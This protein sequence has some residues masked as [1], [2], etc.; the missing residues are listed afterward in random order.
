MSNSNSTAINQLIANYS[1]ETTPGAATKIPDY[2]YILPPNTTVYVTLLPGSSIDD[3]ISIC[4]RL[5]SE[6][7]VPVPHYVA[8]HIPDQKKLE[9]S[10]Q[11]FRDETGG[12]QIL[13]LAG[14]SSKPVGIYENSMQLLE[15][16]LFDKMGVCQIGV[17]GHPEG[18]PD[19]PP[20]TVKRAL[21]WKNEFSKRTDANMFIIT[22]FCFDA[23]AVIK[24]EQQLVADGIT[25][26]VHIGIP[27]VA[28]IGTLLKHAAAC[29]VGAS[30][31][32]LRKQAR[33]ATK[34]LMNSTPE[35]ILREL[36]DYQSENS[37]SLIEKVHVYPLGGLRK[38][39]DWFSEFAKSEYSIRHKI[40]A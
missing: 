16:G 23:Q 34:L 6:G 25:L 32:F 5:A 1:V 10:L 4:I 38:S 8:R 26:P 11:R 37:D 40:V 15:T 27:G 18:T 7:F 36:A 35:R 14:S 21:D 12:T 3:T 20:A 24:W 31:K 28:T 9:T 17:A 33:S 29:G 22:Q 13:V 19:I 39:V 30:A 2:R